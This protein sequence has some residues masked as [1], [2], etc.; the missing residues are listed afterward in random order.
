MTN[1]PRDVFQ[2]GGLGNNIST[3]WSSRELLLVLGLNVFSLFPSFPLLRVSA[4][5]IRPVA[6]SAELAPCA[7]LLVYN[8]V[9]SGRMYD[10]PV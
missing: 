2:A 7:S 3:S 1:P 10:I 8:L 6:Y 9:K 4:V 5:S